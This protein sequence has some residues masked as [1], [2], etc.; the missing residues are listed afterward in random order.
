MPVRVALTENQTLKLRF[1]VQGGETEVASGKYSFVS[2]C[3][4]SKLR[5]MFLF[6]W[7]RMLSNRES[8]RRSRRR[9]QEHLTTLEEEV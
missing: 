9:K 2:A 7:R 6:F 1:V 8:A 5:L 4:F 3:T